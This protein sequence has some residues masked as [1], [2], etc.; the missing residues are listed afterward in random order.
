LETILKTEN[1]GSNMKTVVLCVSSA[2]VGAYF[3]TAT[4]AVASFAFNGACELTAGACRLVLRV[5]A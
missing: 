5:V 2:L 3:N 4:L 1:G